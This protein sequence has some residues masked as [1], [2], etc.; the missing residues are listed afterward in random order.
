[1]HAGR[2]RARTEQD[3]VSV[4]YSERERYVR[5]RTDVIEANDAE[6]IEVRRGYENVA[7]RQTREKAGR[8]EGYS[9]ILHP[10]DGQTM[11]GWSIT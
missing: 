8:I 2:D 1:M 6:P 9:V 7:A 3:S 4:K 10:N 5:K 11:K